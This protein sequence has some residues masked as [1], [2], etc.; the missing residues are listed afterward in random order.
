MDFGDLRLRTLIVPQTILLV[1][2]GTSITHFN[3]GSDSGGSVGSPN[4]FYGNRS[5]FLRGAEMG[6]HTQSRTIQREGTCIDYDICQLWSW[7]SLRHPH[8]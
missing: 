2:K 1:P 3:I 7:K 8:R 5:S 4:G 6:I